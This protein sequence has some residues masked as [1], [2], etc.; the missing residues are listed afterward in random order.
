MGSG[1][2]APCIR[3]WMVVISL[4]LW[5]PY[6]L[7]W[8]SLSYLYGRIGKPRSRYVGEGKE[9][10]NVLYITTGYRICKAL[11]SQTN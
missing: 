1:D 7:E 9:K 2:I 8:N 4:T 3:H 10:I 11:Y 5:Q 6:P